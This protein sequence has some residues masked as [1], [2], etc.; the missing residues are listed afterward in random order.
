MTPPPVLNALEMVKMALTDVY[1]DLGQFV[2]FFRRES[3]KGNIV[4]EGSR[5]FLLEA[6]SQIVIHV[7][8]GL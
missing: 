4:G 7:R 8:D 2:V 6:A 3:G 1:P 5:E